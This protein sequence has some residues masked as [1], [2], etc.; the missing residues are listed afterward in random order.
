MAIKFNDTC[1]T[2]GINFN[3]KKSIFF[4][5]V[6]EMINSNELVAGDIVKTTGY[7]TSGDGGHAIYVVKA[8]TSGT[9]GGII[10]QSTATPSIGFYIMPTNGEVNCASLGMVQNDITKRTINTTRLINAVQASFGIIVDGIYHFENAEATPVSCNKINIRGANNTATMVLYGNLFKLEDGVKSIQSKDIIFTSYTGRKPWIF[11]INTPI[12]IDKIEFRNCNF[13]SSISAFRSFD[14]VTYNPA[15]LDYGVTEFVF[16][17]NTIKDNRMTFINMLD[18]PFDKFVA[19]NN[20]VYNFDFT[21]FYIGITNTHSFP[22]EILLAMKT[23]IVNN[24][25]VVN[26][27]LWWGDVD[28]VYLAFI[29][30]ECQEIEYKNNHVE[31]IKTLGVNATYDA[32]L[33]AKKVI[34]T[35]NVWKNNICFNVAKV[36]LKNTLMKSKG[37]ADGG[38]RHFEGNTYIIDP[39]I[40]TRVGNGAT[41]D[42]TIINFID[43]IS[44]VKKWVIK[45]NI[46]DVYY[47]YF[48]NDPLEID[49]FQVEGN[50]FNF[51]KSARY[52]M[53]L[54]TMAGVDYSQ[55]MHTFVNNTISSTGDFVTGSESL[56]IA[57]IYDTTSGANRPSNFVISNNTI[58][59]S[60]LKYVIY[61][62]M[63]KNLIIENNHFERL[64]GSTNKDT[65][66]L[67]YQ[68]IVENFT[69]RNNKFVNLDDSVY[70]TRIST[71]SK[72]FDEDYVITH[73]GATNSL[74]KLF[75]RASSEATDYT[76]PVNVERVYEVYQAGNIS[77]FSFVYKV[78]RDAG[79]DKITFLDET[80]GNPV[81]YTLNTAEGS[82][83]YVKTT[84]TIVGGLRIRF[85]NSSTGN[86]TYFH[87]Y[88][89]T[90]GNKLVKI[91][92]IGLRG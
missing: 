20:R 63:L 69:N 54:E 84:G 44:H 3:E 59:A 87:L 47:L 7:Y 74:S 45:N 57:T 22:T 32:Y 23:C 50:T 51:V 15:V 30:A 71:A 88:A 81:I 78:Y 13:I 31:G 66:Q 90:T 29:L 55:C 79:V 61:T 48:M 41:M 64:A 39:D 62:A 5:S 26:D 8:Y 86:G 89:S 73:N 2:G 65:L 40:A 53:N 72:I 14:L 35:N 80:T 92:T 24:N 1:D 10:I 52:I 11:A 46:F 49:E 17:N 28:A 75:V 68:G 18:M 70:E 37:N 60:N 33:S 43:N 6:S 91:K 42:M 85:T 27:D 12:R 82:A 34:S 67:G 9:D 58:V 56:T 83:T 21:I 77:R 16:E 19:Q 36:M 76:I 25:Y 38:T 4:N